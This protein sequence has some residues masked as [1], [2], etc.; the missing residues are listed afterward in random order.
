MGI[1]APE[2]LDCYGPESTQALTELISGKQVRLEKD[3]TARDEFGRYLRYVY[4]DNPDPDRNN[5][6]VNQYLIEQGYAQAQ[7]YGPDKRYRLYLVQSQNNAQRANRGIWSACDIQ[8][9]SQSQN[10]SQPTDRT[11]ERTF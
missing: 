2:Y 3:L 5:I 7:S 10:D 6:L 11:F 8:T 1:N 9:D 4:L